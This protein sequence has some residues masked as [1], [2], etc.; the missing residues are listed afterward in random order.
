VSNG[1]PAAATVFAQQAKGAGVTVKV[2]NVT[3]DVFWGGQYLSWPF[4][5]DN[6]G[7][8]G[9]LTQTGM[10]TMPGALYDETHW[11][12]TNSKYMALVNEAYTTVDDTK[13]NELITEASTMEYNEGGYIVYAFDNQVDAYSAKV[14]GAVPD[15]SGLG[16]AAANARYRLVYFV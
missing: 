5:M 9:Y 4:A 10:G 1:A 11:A 12:K 15:Y 13:R 3:G 2:D 8:R 6:W 16:S 14:A 7:T